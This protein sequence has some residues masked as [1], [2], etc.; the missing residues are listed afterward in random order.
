ME[1]QTDGR[2]ERKGTAASAECFTK[3]SVSEPVSVMI[4][5]MM[6]ATVMMIGIIIIIIIR[7]MVVICHSFRSLSSTFFF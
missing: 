4:E 2:T 6:A 1:G 7:M 3:K 5:A